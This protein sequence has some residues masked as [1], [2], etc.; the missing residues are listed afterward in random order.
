VVEERLQ[1]HGGIRILRHHVLEWRERLGEVRRGIAAERGDTALSDS[2][3]A[4]LAHQSGDV[5]TWS[6]SY[7]RARNAALLGR[8]D[9]AVARMREAIDEGIW[10]PY[11]HIDPAFAT[12]RQRADFAALTAPKD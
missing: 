2:L 11:V 3:D 12:L 9:D 7:Y 1:D 10:L 5:V 8:G 6:A 4:W